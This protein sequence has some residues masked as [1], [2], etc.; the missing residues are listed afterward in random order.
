MPVFGIDDEGLLVFVNAAAQDLL[1]LEVDLLGQ[2][3][4]ELL[5][6]TLLQV[7]DG[8]PMLVTLAR[9][10]WWA[11]SRLLNGKAH[12]HLVVLLPQNGAST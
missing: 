6:Q 4:S 11:M 8:A 7:L 3:A 1:G 9:Q 5:P 10:R 2:A 12:G